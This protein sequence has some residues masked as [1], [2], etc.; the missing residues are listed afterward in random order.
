[1]TGASRSLI[2]LALGLGAGLALQ[3]AHATSLITVAKALKPI[4]TLWLAG[5]QMTLVP[6]IFALVT[7]GV[8]EWAGRGGG[9]TL[10]FAFGLFAALATAGALG[11]SAL[12]TA[13]LSLWAPVAHVGGGAVVAAPPG[14]I[15]SLGEQLVALVPTNPV[16]AAAQMQVAPLVVFALLLGLALVR[17]GV[18]EREAILS[19]LSGVSRAMLVIVDWVLLAAPAGIFVLALGV[20]L[21]E[22]AGAAGV[23]LQAVIMTSAVVAVAL[24]CCYLVAW[25]GGGVPIRA[26]ARAAAGPQAVAAGTTSSMATLPAMVEAAERSLGMSAA[27]AGTVLPLAVSVFRFGSVT[28]IAGCAIFAAH[29]AGLQPSLVQILVMCGVVVVTNVGIAGLPAAAVLYAAEAPAFQALGAPLDFLPLLIATAALPDVLDTACNVTADLAAATVV[30]RF[31]RRR[32]KTEPA[33]A[34]SVA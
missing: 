22:G 16:G 14:G 2:G 13:G 31:A 34:G 26:F 10:G 24:A 18:R 11:A 25:L 32:V 5:L 17:V 8:A 21:T 23:V 4:G 20:A 7:T 12:M 19:A 28:L 15:P 33:Q 6:L 3:A 30:H 29:A 9:R 27:T 1:M